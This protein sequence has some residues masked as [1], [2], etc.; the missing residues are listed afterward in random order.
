MDNAPALKLQVAFDD[1][2]HE[3]KGLLFGG[4]LLDAFAEVSVAEFS[5]EVG[6]VLGGVDIM[7]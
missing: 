2:L 6:I 1:L 4:R 7:E 3:S 5:D